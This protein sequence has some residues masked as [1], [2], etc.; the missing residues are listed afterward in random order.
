VNAE[1]VENHIV[2]F[3]KVNQVA[4]VAMPDE[5]FGEKICAFVIPQNGESFSLEELREYLIKDRKIA[6][7]KAPE[8]LEF[9]DAFPVTKVGKLDKKALREKIAETLKEER[10]I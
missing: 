6:K 1:E 4:V 5:K 8:R 9:I 10:K 7:F 2:K 3:P